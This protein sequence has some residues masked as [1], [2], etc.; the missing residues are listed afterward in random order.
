LGVALLSDLL[1]LLTLHLRIIYFATAALSR[2]SMT[3]LLGLW[4]LFRGELHFKR[5]RNG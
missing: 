5:Y 4:E 1:S 2:M 3:A